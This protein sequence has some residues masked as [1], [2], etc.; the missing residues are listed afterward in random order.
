MG[1]AIA[2]T[3]FE[4]QD[5]EQ[6][7]QRLNEQLAELKQLIRAP[8]FGNDE[9]MLGAELEMYLLDQDWQVACKNQKLLKAL[10]DPQF[11]VELNQYNLELNLSA[12][13]ISGRPFS[14]LLK[15]MKEKSDLVQHK[16]NELGINTLPIGILP[17]L[18]EQHLQ[19]QF[20]TDIPR[21]RVL[22]EQL[23]KLRGDDFKVNING[24][25]PVSLRSTNVTA[26]GAN[27]SFQVH[28][29]VEHNRFADTFNAAQLTLPLTI[30]M[31]ANSPI[32]LGHKVWDETRIALFKQSLDV[33]KKDL[34]EWQ[35]PAR[36]SFGTGWVRKDC[37]ELFA[38]AVSNYAVLIPDCTAPLTPTSSD[39]KTL[40]SL[41]EL[42]LH[43]GTIW[44][45]N[46]PVYCNQGQGHV[47]IEFRALPAGPSDIDMVANA[48]FSIG[49][50]VGVAEHI[51]DYISC[52][53]FALAEY[54]FYRA[55]QGGLDAKI[56]WPGTGFHQPQEV[57]I[58]DVIKEMLPIARKG[59]EKLAVQSTEIDTFLG[60][61]S[62]RLDSGITGARWQKQVLDLLDK[63]MNRKQACQE[64]V[65][66]YSRHMR[67]GNEVSQWPIS[68]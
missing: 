68:M 55:A 31:A 22:T 10:D 37:W 54:N 47:R 57:A 5:Y 58:V 44:P 38:E 63:Q 48:A 50:A 34:F 16:A 19:G 51:E 56:L 64:L 15:Q 36:V 28:M 6:F 27:T 21:Y 39:Y 62:R 25:D 18:E 42:N 61:I 3:H 4:P 59:L 41:R 32:L 20:M 35:Q 40:P 46:R 1:G 29:M 26:E 66:L 9:L 24:E 52:I 7:R 43:M 33:R 65:A 12:F 23:A 49:L 2:K 30:A 60:V 14:H 45:W 11:Q 8:D 67:S 17:T 13:S 53:P